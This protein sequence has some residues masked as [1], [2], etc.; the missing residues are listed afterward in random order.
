METRRGGRVPGLSGTSAW[1]EGWSAGEYEL[2]FEVFTGMPALHDHLLARLDPRP[3]QR[4]LDL[5]T[6][7]GRVARLAARAG[8][9]VT[10]QDSARGLIETAR[11]LAGEA[12]LSIR[13][14]V[15]DCQALPYPDASFD[16]ISSAVGLIF[17][18][19]HHAVARELARLCR[20]GGRIGIVAW[21]PDEEFTAIFEPFVPP[22]QPD[23]GNVSDWGREMYVLDLL[24]SDFEL[25]FDESDAPITGE[26]GEAIW[27]VWLRSVGPTRL[28][29]ASLDPARRDQLR[30][31]FVGYFGRFRIDGGIEQPNPYLLILGTRREHRP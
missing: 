9:E 15:G 27:N 22:S 1:E 16:V 18:P 2:V 31:A 8:A 28:L 25:E 12:G 14:D 19:N 13:F 30:E 4:W 23:A 10:G 29:Y 26:S 7:T 11:R 24:H 3:G 21:R 6:G 20:P 5:A 17:A